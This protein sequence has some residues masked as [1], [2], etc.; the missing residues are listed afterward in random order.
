MIRLKVC[1]APPPPPYFVNG[2]QQ[3]VFFLLDHNLLSVI[4]N[5]I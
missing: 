3:H 4:L 2:S 5:H 1:D